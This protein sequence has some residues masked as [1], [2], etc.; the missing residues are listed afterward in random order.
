ME[1]DQADAKAIA[2]K[3]K[4]DL[5][6]GRSHQQAQIR[7]KGKLIARFGIRRS[8]KDVPHDY[9]PR[10]I[11]VTTRQAKDLAA[12]PMSYDQWVSVMKAKGFIRD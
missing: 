6:E 12:C 3:L 1:L 4:A 8:S 7:Y 10:E 5:T 9:I 2:T 11:H